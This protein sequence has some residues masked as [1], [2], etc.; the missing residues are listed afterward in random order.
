MWKYSG[1]TSI[2]AGIFVWYLLKSLPLWQTADFQSCSSYTV[3]SY[4]GKITLLRVIQK[5]YKFRRAFQLQRQLCTE[6]DCLAMLELNLVFFFFTSTMTALFLVKYVE[7][8]SLSLWI[9]HYQHVQK[10]TAAEHA[11]QITMWLCKAGSWEINCGF[12]NSNK[13]HL[14]VSERKPWF[15]QYI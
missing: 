12:L 3:D 14:Q 5:R 15:L 11:L 10:Q 4:S 7:N 1:I 9:L 8:Y 6:L 2:E 13:A